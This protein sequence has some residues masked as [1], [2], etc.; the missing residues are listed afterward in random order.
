MRSAEVAKESY[1]RVLV[2][3]AAK[4][5]KTTSI[6]STA[7]KPLIINCDVEGGTQYAAKELGAEFYEI[8]VSNTN[9]V[10]AKNAW[11]QARRAAK[12]LAEAGEIR[13]IILDTV[14]LLGESLL[15]DLSVTLE[16]FELWKAYYDQVIGGYKRLAELPAHIFVV[17]HMDPGDENGVGGIL[18]LIP[19]KAKRVLTA[20]CSDC[21]LFDYEAGR[22]P[23]ERAFLLGPQKFWTHSGRNIRRTC[24]VKPDAT[25]LLK[26]M[27]FEP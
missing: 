16:G 27:G 14:T 19:G 25:A 17:G 20:M 8:R 23:D 22:K 5:G 11:T 7:P 10:G 3:G 2:L 1:A 21:V 26:E 15:E 6:A 18:P 13:S 24:V 4:I 12:E 9:G